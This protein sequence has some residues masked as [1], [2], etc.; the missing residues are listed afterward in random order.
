MLC[1]CSLRNSTTRSRG[2]GT[3][4]ATN[5]RRRRLAARFLD[6]LSQKTSASGASTRSSRLSFSSGSCPRAVADA[7]NAWRSVFAFQVRAACAAYSSSWPTTVRRISGFEPRFTSTSV[8]SASWS[9]IRRSSDHRAPASEV[10]AIPFSRVTRT[11]RRG[12]PGRICS[13]SNRSDA[14]Q[15]A[16]EAVEKRSSSSGSSFPS[17]PL[18]YMRSAISRLHVSFATQA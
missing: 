5:R 6:T 4:S 8:G 2:S 3:S 7:S 14:Q 12:S 18:V 9:T 10:S 17:S 11:Q 1:I 13:P 15:S 16:P